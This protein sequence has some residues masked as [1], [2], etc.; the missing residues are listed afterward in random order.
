[1][2]KSLQSTIPAVTLSMHMD[3]DINR[4]SN[5]YMC[6][7]VHN[8]SWQARI[9]EYEGFVHA[10]DLQPWQKGSNFGKVPCIKVLPPEANF[11]SISEG[12]VRSIENECDRGDS[13]YGKKRVVYGATTRGRADI[14][15]TSS[16]DVNIPLGFHVM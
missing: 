12:V 3:F 6:E 1:M 16:L 13:F 7:N 2:H 15:T 4:D 5:V 9:A 10:A 14:V 11:R 8:V